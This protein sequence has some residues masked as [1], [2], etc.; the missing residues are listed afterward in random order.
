MIAN[1]KID[2]YKLFL[3]ELKKKLNA[4][5]YE[6]LSDKEVLLRQKKYGE[7]VLA[8]EEVHGV[9]KV[10]IAQFK[11]P[12]VWV[13]LVAGVATFFLHEFLDMTVI[14]L[15]L[16]INIV[17]GIVQE[18]KA[19]NA[20]AKLKQS[21][22]KY[23]TVLRNS[24]RKII[25]ASELVPG[26]I[27]L[28]ESGMVIPAD[29]RILDSTDLS[30]NESVLTGEWVEV[31]KDTEELTKD[32]SISEQSN[33]V[34]MGT[35]VVSG[36]ARAVIVAIGDETQMGDIAKSLTEKSE[37]STPLQKSVKR[38]A[39]YIAIAIS[40]VLVLIFTLGVWR[41]LPASEM[42]LIAIAIAV[43]AMPEGLPAAVTVVLAI[44]MES[45]LKKKGLVRNLLAAETLGS[46]TVILTDKTGTLTKAKMTVASIITASSFYKKDEVESKNKIIPNGADNSD[47]LA[48]SILTS[49]AFVEGYDDATSE[50]IVRGRPVEKAVV[51]AGLETGLKQDILSKSNLE[52]DVIPFD[53]EKR[54]AASMRKLAGAKSNR[55]YF[56][57]SPELLLEQSTHFYFNGNKRKITENIRGIFQKI[58]EEKSSEGMRLVGVAYKDTD[59]NSFTHEEKENSVSVLSSVVFSGFI[60]IHDPIRED[61]PNSIKE[62]KDAGAKIIMVTGDNENTAK[63]V[64]IDVGITTRNGNVLS[65]S[66]IKDMNDKELLLAIKKT[67]VFARI[68]PRQKMRIVQVLKN[69][70]EVVAMTGD[71]INDAPA[72]RRANIGIALGSGTDVA[73]EAADIVLLNN[74]FTVIVDAIEEGRR[75]LDNLKKIVAYL[76]STG[77]SEILV[78]G[79]ALAF[80]VP[81]PLLPA[82]ILWTN[83][84]EEGFMN[85][86]FAFE[87][88]ES[89]IMKRNPNSPMMRN[90][91]TP[92]LQKLIIILGLVTGTLLTI[93]YFILLKTNISIEEARTVMFVL[94]SVDSMFFT[95]SLKDVH[96][97]I[98]KI[99]IFNNKYLIYALLASILTL[100]LALFVPFLRK[101]L[102][103]TTLT[104]SEILLVFAIGTFNLF[105]IEIIKYIYFGNK[106]TKITK[107]LT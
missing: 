105:V 86:S 66:D 67:R 18:E 80:G 41:G 42:F 57:G 102:S 31:S 107:V 26:D 30:V 7:N 51:L 59:S 100:L 40:L 106:K 35:L 70:G 64:A 3:V 5:F 24:E 74:S 53:S 89:N 73:K 96:V 39:R 36:M 44:G 82:Q 91:L 54:F 104:P 45:I 16:L 21:Q 15:A 8:E 34:W 63:K 11:S 38:L 103:L 56:T 20:F 101:L 71:G 37:S 46:T 97:P 4:D 68:L 69:S 88:K 65:G 14:F 90:I 93:V 94:L 48:M 78:V 87:P 79:S 58:Q 47:V 12:L 77:F 62:A 92:N 95:F 19:S 23:T 84:I 61:V 81:I 28:I 9:V 49:D 25:L 13:L 10:A 33:M 6:G 32:V 99:N 85:F 27:I 83:I 43:A 55:V 1:K 29:A 75:I 50:W 22:K 52:L 2:W 60:L 98:W 72:L 76:L 17:V